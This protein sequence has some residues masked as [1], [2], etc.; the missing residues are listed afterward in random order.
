MCTQ[1][2]QI[3]KVRRHK[4][5]AIRFFPVRDRQQKLERGSGIDDEQKARQLGI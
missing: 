5:H 1:H 2:R 4:K 3:E